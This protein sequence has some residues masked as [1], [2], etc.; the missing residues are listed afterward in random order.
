[1]CCAHRSRPTMAR[2]TLVCAFLAALV[3]TAQ[4]TDFSGARRHLMQAR[5][6]SDATAM[7]D[8][9]SGSA[10]ATSGIKV[11][12]GEGSA[13][14]LATTEINEQSAVVVKDVWVRLQTEIS[15]DATCEA[16]RLTSD[17]Q[18]EESVAA[19]AEVYTSAFG[20]VTIDGTGAGCADAAATGDA[21]ATAYLQVIIDVAL[22]LT[23]E[24][25]EEK[26]NEAFAGVYANLLSGSVAQ[27]WAEAFASACGTA[28]GGETFV[29]AEQNSFA[30]AVA[31]PIIIAFVWAEVS[32]ECGE[33]A[34]S[35]S[36]LSASIS[37]DGATVAGADSSTIVEGEGTATA[38]GDA[39][40]DTMEAALGDTTELDARIEGF[41]KCTGS[42]AICCR[43]DDDICRCT[44]STRE[45]AF[46]CAATKE[47]GSTKTLWTE[48]NGDAS[49]GPFK[50]WC[51]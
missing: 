47:V 8:S 19:I 16:A 48:D 29:L 44:L 7:S 15:D 45:S 49:T 2:I 3:V 38:A 37:D 9:P 39:G 14:A 18:V 12:D 46:R 34:Y 20:T 40:A 42:Q 22:E 11:T 5:A 43:V 50:C 36:K 26:A 1:M 30:R 17:V 27:A 10:A 31:E 32:Q 23:F 33:L 24:G 4:A 6:S 35:E 21:T 41:D 25:D 51:D 13:S 28:E